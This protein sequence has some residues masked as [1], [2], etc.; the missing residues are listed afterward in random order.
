LI[1]LPKPER[2]GPKP[3]KRI[4][5]NARI[6]HSSLSRHAKLEKQADD[7]WALIIRSRA[8]RCVRCR[9]RPVAQADHLV[10][11]THRGTRWDLRNGAPLCAGCHQR[12]TSDTDEH[13]RLAIGYLGAELWQHLNVS[14]HMKRIDPSLAIIALQHVVKE[15]GLEEEAKRRRLI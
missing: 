2:R 12:V 3:R 4:P 5:R 10:T 13:V 14:K 8:E 7:L 11:R 9:I 6:R 15:C 1:A